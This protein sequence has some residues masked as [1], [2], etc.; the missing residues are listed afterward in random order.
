MESGFVV[1]GPARYD[2][3]VCATHL[4]VIE[5]AVRTEYE[6]LLVNAG[7]WRRWRIRLQIRA[8]I[9]RRLEVALANDESPEPSQFSLW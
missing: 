3:A 1:D 2:A 7:A 9:A 4:A 8:E 5:P 6:P